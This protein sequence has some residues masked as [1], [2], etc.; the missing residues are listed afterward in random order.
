MTMTSWLQLIF[1]VFGNQLKNP[2][3]WLTKHFGRQVCE[4]VANLK[5][6]LT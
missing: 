1:F 3:E 4:L 2:K 6:L 5:S